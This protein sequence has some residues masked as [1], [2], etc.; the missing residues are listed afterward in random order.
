M[1]TSTWTR[2]R[3]ASSR[4]GSA[5]YPIKSTLKAPGIKHLKPSYDEPPSN[6][7]FEL[8]LRRYMKG[9]LDAGAA[10]GH[11]VSGGSISGM[12]GLFFCKGPVKNFQDATGRGLNS[13]T[14]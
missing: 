2:S 6:F 5:C 8:N 7:A 4:Y 3:A 14:F 1:R 13:S 11:D 12:F 10:A 9:I